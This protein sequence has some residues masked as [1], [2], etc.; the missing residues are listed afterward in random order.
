[1]GTFISTRGRYALRVLLDLADSYG[2]P[3]VPLKDIAERQGISLK[4]LESIMPVLVR[5]GIV[6]GSHGKGGGYELN[7]PPS[8]CM[9]GNVLRLTEGSI[10]TVSCLEEGSA[11]CERAPQCRTLPM[12][13]KLDDLINGYLDTVS[14]KDLM[15]EPQVITVD[16]EQ[17][18]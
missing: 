13:K 15:P 2:G 4:Y 9:V 12:W 17:S 18:S 14:I 6:S 16:D 10:C 11:P 3:R 1:M 8:E 5:E 7:I